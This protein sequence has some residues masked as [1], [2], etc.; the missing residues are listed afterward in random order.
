MRTDTRLPACIMVFA[1]YTALVVWRKRSHS[2]ASPGDWDPLVEN[3]KCLVAIVRGTG[4]EF[5]AGKLTDE[6]RKF[7]A[8]VRVIASGS[9]MATSES[10]TLYL[11]TLQSSSAL[12]EVA[13]A[14][15]WKP[16]IEKLPAEGYLIRSGV[17]AGK[18]IVVLA[19]RDRTGV[20]YAASDL[21]NYYLDRAA[22]NVAVR[23]MNYTE[24]PKMPHRWLWN[25]DAR[26]N[27]E[28][29]D[30]YDHHIAPSYSARPF[31]KPPGAFLRNMKL[32]VDY[33]S[34]HKLNGLIV[35]GFLRDN[36]GG[37]Q[38]AQELCRYA[39][40]RGASNYAGREYRPQIRWLL[41]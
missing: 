11:G 36:H 6:L 39:N 1:V 40:E 23:A 31:R 2:S 10:V 9:G 19:G 5:A 13:S 37:V 4:D 33:M 30:Y 7:A 3:Q 28:L 20:I 26:T 41:S 38:A 21:K 25:W 22:G 8:H 17:L 15:G 24:V 32:C 12:A 35:W 27:W 14:L 18:N 16:G 29:N 34:E